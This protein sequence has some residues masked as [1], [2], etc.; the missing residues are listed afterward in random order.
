[1][2]AEVYDERCRTHDPRP[3]P[4]VPWTILG[5]IMVRADAP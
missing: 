4:E 5:G 1:M 2:F 3:V